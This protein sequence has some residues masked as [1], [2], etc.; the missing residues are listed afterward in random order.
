M[1]VEVNIGPSSL[2]PIQDVASCLCFYLA[3]LLLA[4]SLDATC[5]WL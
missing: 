1:C 2:R 5:A 4:K 3:S